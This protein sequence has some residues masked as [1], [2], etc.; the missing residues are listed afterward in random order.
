MKKIKKNAVARFKIKVLAFPRELLSQAKISL[1]NLIGYF[2]SGIKGALE[3]PS[4]YQGLWNKNYPCCTDKL[5]YRQ[6]CSQW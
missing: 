1:S 4:V 3:E 2:P 5:R 6:Y